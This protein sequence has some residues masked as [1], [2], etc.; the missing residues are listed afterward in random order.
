MIGD[1]PITVPLLQLNTVVF[2]LVVGTKLKI[3]PEHIST[4]VGGF[5]KISFG[6]TLTVTL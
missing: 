3:V 5:N 6:F 1:V 2:I 4:A